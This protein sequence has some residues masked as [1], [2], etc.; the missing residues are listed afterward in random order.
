ML[1]EYIVADLEMTG[2]K[3]SRDKILEI[4]AVYVKNGEIQ[5]EFQTFVNPEITIPQN[6]VE[7]TGITDQMA[8]LGLSV[9]EAV[10]KFLV[11]AG[12]LPIVGH[13]IRYDYEFLKYNAI[14]CDLKMENTVVDTLKLARQLLKE[15]EK[16]S[17]DALCEYFQ[18]IREKNHRALEDARATGIIFEILKRQF[19][20]EHQE[21]FLP[22]VVICKMKKQYPATPVQK[23]YLK[24]LQ[25]YYKIEPR[26][27][28]DTLTRSEASRITD[29]ILFQYGK[30]PYRKREY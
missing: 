16:K 1:R 8:V 18:I 14:Q 17:L 29:R 2:L 19:Q 13:N 23:K 6:I 5:E 15:P 26:I 25:E 9:A 20:E 27:N 21:M 4:G 10:E 22:K 24:E 3:P 7:L 30:P 28:P 12:E 11:F